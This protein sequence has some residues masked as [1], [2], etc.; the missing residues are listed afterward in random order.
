MTAAEP[1]S[2]PQLIVAP[3][4][5][6][7]EP[8]NDPEGAGVL[9]SWADLGAAM[10]TDRPWDAGE[11]GFAA[12]AAAL[13]S[14]GTVMDPLGELGAAGVGWV[15]EHVEFLHEPL[16]WLAG[17]PAQIT[18]QAHT[19]HNMSRELGR[20][21]Q[22]HQQNVHGLTGWDGAAME[23]YREAAGRYTHCV[24]SVSEHAET[25]SQTVSGTGA[26]VGAVRAMIRDEIAELVWDLA[27]KA[28]AMAAA[29]APT[30]G[31][32]VAAF[33]TSA[34][35]RAAQTAAENGIRVAELLDRLAAATDRLSDLVRRF[36][37]MAETVSSGLRRV[38]EVPAMLDV[39]FLGDLARSPIGRL[40][41]SAED[42]VANEGIAGAVEMGK[43]HSEAEQAL[44]GDRPSAP[45]PT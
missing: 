21:A 7:S 30:A 39:D 13:D 36:G 14:L 32:S 26:T 20:I 25:V 16:D 34:V 9:S 3:E 5:D 33:L 31:A 41:V 28:I 11:I 44:S 17:D 10:P 8:W 23:A 40:A 45:E 37:V 12:S 6:R 29:A 35:A 22:D 38:D 24:G 2:E 18:A 19:W 1:P 4:N 42:V 43:E 15:I 27:V